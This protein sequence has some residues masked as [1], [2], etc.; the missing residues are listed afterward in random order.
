M[1]QFTYW[2]GSFRKLG[3][4]TKKRGFW[5]LRLLFLEINHINDSATHSKLLPSKSQVIYKRLK[6]YLQIARLYVIL[7][8]AVLGGEIAVPWTRNPLQRDWIAP[9]DF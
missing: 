6:F 1:R 7:S 8:F 9:P 2:G 3:R 4:A 5:L